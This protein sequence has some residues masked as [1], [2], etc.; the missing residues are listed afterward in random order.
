MPTERD[1][2]NQFELLQLHRQ[3]VQ[4]FRRQVLAHGGEAF[5][6]PLAQRGLAE[7][8]AG[9]ATIK[10][11]LRNWGVV[12]EDLPDDLPP[13]TDLPSVTPRASSSDDQRKGAFIT[14]GTFHGQVIGYQENHGS[15]PAPAPAA[16]PQCQADVLLVTVTDVETRAVF[17]ALRFQSGRTPTPR[18]QGDKTYYDLGTLGG[19]RA[20]LVRSEM[21]AGTP[22]GA[23]ATLYTAIGALRPAAIVMVGIAFGTDPVRQRIGDVL[24]ARQL[25]PYEPQRLGAGPDGAQVLVSRGDRVTAPPRALDRCRDAELSW[26]GRVQFGL[27]L[28]GEKLIDHAP[29]VAALLAREP[30]AVGGEMEGA[31]LYV[32]ASQHKIDW[33][34]IKAIC[35]WADGNKD[36]DKAQNQALAAKNAAGFVL[37]MLA[38]GGFAPDIW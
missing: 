11:V 12:L 23:L 9:I 15:A 17:E 24:V 6:P 14:G 22:G 25:H 32:A 4:I 19:A 37:H 5:A 8:Y 13:D 21:G 30:E 31:G 10:V 35:D 29:A 28:S 34:L 26:S 16:A 33:L 18:Y 7:S 27:M 3:N 2:R 36:Q 38:Q 20:W 1:I